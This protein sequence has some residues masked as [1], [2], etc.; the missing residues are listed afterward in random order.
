MS[1]IP[2]YIPTL[3][4]DINYNPAKVYP[5]LYFYNGKIDCEPYWM[6][7]KPTSG[8]TSV[9]QVELSSFPY[10]DHY[11]VVTG[12]FPSIGSKSLLFQNENAV[13]GAIPSSS[14]Y[15]DYW[16]TYINLLYDPKTRL[17]NCKGIIPLA[18]YYK[19]EL[20]DIVEWRGNLFHLRAINDYDLKTGKCNLQL[21]GPVIAD[22]FGVEYDCNFTFSSTNYVTTSTTT[23][24]STSTTTTTTASPL[25]CYGYWAYNTGSTIGNVTYTC[26]F[27]GETLS[28]TPPIS[29]NTEQYFVSRTLPVVTGDVYLFNPNTPV[30]PPNGLNTGSWDYSKNQSIELINGFDKSWISYYNAD[31]CSFDCDLYF[32][33]VE[34]RTVNALS[35]SVIYWGLVGQNNGAISTGSCAPTTTTTTSSPT[36]TTTSTTTTTTAAP[37]NYYYFVRRYTCPGCTIGSTS[38]AISSTPLVV[39]NFYGYPGNEE[40]FEILS[41]T[42]STGWSVDTYGMTSFT[43]CALYC[44]A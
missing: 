7:Y 6:E 24:T 43:S 25:S 3:I 5:R 22:T 30:A 20:N 15:T 11:N 19:M 40:C 17:I 44:T 34:S 36:T 38:I 10:V 18:D 4:S 42:S 35:G 13:Y 14:L 21:L 16:Q 27:T 33:V 9:T 1:N 29:D 39:G 8:S 41:S 31:S 28:F 23:T 37:D 12:S 32:D 26:C 2:I